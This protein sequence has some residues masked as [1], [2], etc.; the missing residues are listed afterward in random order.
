MEGDKLN[1]LNLFAIETELVNKMDLDAITDDFGTQKSSRKPMNTRHSI[2]HFEYIIIN[3]LSIFYYHIFIIIFY[4]IFFTI[5][6]F[7]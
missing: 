5:K 7:I 4:I 6:F 2:F 3:Y 1:S